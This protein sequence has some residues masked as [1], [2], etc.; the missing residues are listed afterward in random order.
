M[1]LPPSLQKKDATC[2]VWEVSFP[3]IWEVILAKIFGARY[4]ATDGGA[5]LR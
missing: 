1:T 2:R 4:T 3:A 5:P